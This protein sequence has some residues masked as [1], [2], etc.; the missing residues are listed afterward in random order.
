[1]TGTPSNLRPALRT[2]LFEVLREYADEADLELEFTDETPLF[3][4]ESAID[5]LGLV[6]IITEFE[7][8]INDTY[9]TE[10]VL[11]DDRAMA[12]KRSPFRSPARLV[13]FALERL[14][15]ARGEGEGGDEASK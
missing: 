7:T 3:G 10:L 14:V 4:R 13:D 9:D 2:M 12:M 1:M 15:E 5:S 8:Q 6:T 11:A